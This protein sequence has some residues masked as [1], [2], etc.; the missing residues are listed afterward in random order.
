MDGVPRAIEQARA[1]IKQGIQ[2]RTFLGRFETQ[3]QR[4][5]ARKPPRSAWDYEKNVS[6]VSV[7]NMLLTRLDR[8]G[9]AEKI[10]AFASRFGPRQIAVSLMGR[11]HRLMVA[12]Q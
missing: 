4:I 12:L 8:D 7:L 1:M 6:I 10:L 3:Y 5:M 2:V 9:D 11:V